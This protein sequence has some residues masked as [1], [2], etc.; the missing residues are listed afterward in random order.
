MF[1]KLQQRIQFSVMPFVF[2]LSF[3]T[4]K[5]SKFQIPSHVLFLDDIVYFTSAWTPSTLEHSFLS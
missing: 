5:S 2:P 4:T 1:E 3:H